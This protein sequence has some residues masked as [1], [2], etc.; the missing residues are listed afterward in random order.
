MF[1]SIFPSEL[2]KANIIPIHKKKSKFDTENYRPVSILPI[3]PKVF[4]KCMFDQMYSYFHQILSKHQ[5]GFPQGH[6]TQDS[7]LLRVEKLKRS[8]ENGYLAGMLL[9][10]LSKVFYC[11]RR[12]RL[13]AKLAAYGF[14]LPSLCF[15]FSYL[16]DRTQRTKVNNAYRSYT[17][18]KYGVQ[19]GSILGHLL[20]NIDICNL[21]LW[22]CKCEIA[23]YADDNTPYTSDISLSLVLEKLQSS[24]H[25]LF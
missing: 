24:T 7:L 1:S 11:L 18:I 2:K 3:L 4:E 9:T 19:Q 15:I 23:S 14:D 5:C 13:I 12:D 20:F 8:L 16:P 25:D 10:D 21:F 6:S 17:N 22:D